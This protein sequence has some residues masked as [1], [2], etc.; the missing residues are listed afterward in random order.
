M[1]LLG[2]LGIVRMV[3]QGFQQVAAP[4][5]LVDKANIFQRTLWAIEGFFMVFAGKMQLPYGFGDWYSIPSRG[6]AGSVWRPYH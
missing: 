6:F 2:N 5:G 4:G 3:Y 1:V